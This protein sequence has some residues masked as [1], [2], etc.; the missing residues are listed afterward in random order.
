MTEEYTTTHFKVLIKCIKTIY[1]KLIAKYAYTQTFQYFEC[2]AQ[3][4]HL[5]IFY[6]LFYFF[7]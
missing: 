2:L 4:K 6:S 5:A 3:I 1:F 7:L